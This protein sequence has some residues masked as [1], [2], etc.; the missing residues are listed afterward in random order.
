MDILTVAPV[1]ILIIFFFFTSTSRLVLPREQPD[2]VDITVANPAPVVMV[3]LDEFPIAS[4]MNDEEKIDGTRF[5]NFASLASDSTWYKNAT[6]AAAY[7]PLAVPSILGGES[8]DRTSCRSP[9]TT[10]TVFSRCSA[11]RTS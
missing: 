2:P 4:L 10:P 1:V 8:P 3:I 11:S 5:P 9:R 6:A 7:T